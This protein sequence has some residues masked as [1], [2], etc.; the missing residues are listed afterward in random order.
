MAD[1]KPSESEEQAG[2]CREDYLRTG[3]ELL[4]ESGPRALTAVRLAAE[5][6]ATTGSFYWHFKN[7][8]EFRRAVREYWRHVVVPEVIA[9]ALKQAEADGGPAIDKLGPLV[10]QTGIYRYDDAMRR[11]AQEDAET[12]NA[13]QEADAWRGRVMTAMMGNTSTAADVT[14][15]IGAA[16]R[17]SSGMPDA[18]RRAKLIAMTTRAL[19]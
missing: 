1:S 9:E 4:A 18:K 5:L 13:L 12:A 7:V 2:R 8:A 14:E 6:E 17:G 16:W 19:A 11:W 10:W 15:L 3:L